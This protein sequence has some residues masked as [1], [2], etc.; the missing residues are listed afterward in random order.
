MH[1]RLLS[2]LLIL[3]VMLVGVAPAA[4]DVSPDRSA[5]ACCRTMQAAAQHDGCPQPI[6]P[7]MRCCAPE[8]NRSS[9]SQAPPAGTTTPQQPDFTLLKGHAAHVPGLP[10]RVGASVAHAFESARLQLPHDPL[11]LRNLV[12]LV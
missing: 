6:A 1:R 2:S 4:A 11:Y 5:H 7:K 3:A 9:G 12:L 8:P 10:A